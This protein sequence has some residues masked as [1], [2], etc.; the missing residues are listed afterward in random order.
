MVLEINTVGILILLQRKHY[1]F[2]NVIVFGYENVLVPKIAGV[3]CKELKMNSNSIV[4]FDNVDD[5][6]RLWREALSVGIYQ[7]T[8]IHAEKN[9]LKLTKELEKYYI[10]ISFTHF[11]FNFVIYVQIPNYCFELKRKVPAKTGYL[12]KT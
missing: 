10:V 8:V 11:S 6:A 9:I 2:A 1:R 4:I 12:R 7:D 3:V 5:V